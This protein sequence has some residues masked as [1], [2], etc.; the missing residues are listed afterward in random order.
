MHIWIATW[1]VA[2]RHNNLDP[3]QPFQFTSHLELPLYEAQWHNAH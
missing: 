3:P 2:S 1:W